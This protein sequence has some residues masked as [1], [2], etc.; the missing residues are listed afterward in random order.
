[1]AALHHLREFVFHVVAEI[2][3]AVFV[4]GAI[5][6]VAGVGGAALIIIEAMHDYADGEAEK[7]VDLPHPP[8][9][10]AG[11]IIVDGDNVDALARQGVQIGG[12]SRHEGLALTCA[13]FGYGAFVKHHAAD[14]LHIEVAL[15]KAAPGGLADG[16]EGGGQN[17]VQRLAFGE[18]GAEHVGA[19]PQILVAQL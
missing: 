18:L 5:G 16:R 10:A 7:L 19:R 3:E 15:A 2:V 9:I 12:E 17:I 13:H 11:E 6:D 4:V 14:H 1:M 8:A